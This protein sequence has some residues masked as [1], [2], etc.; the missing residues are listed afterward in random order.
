MNPQSGL[1][2]NLAQKC[3]DHFGDQCDQLTLIFP[4]K[5]SGMYFAQY[6]SKLY[7]KPIW[8]PKIYSLEEFVMG[9]QDKVLADDFQL[10][11]LLYQAYSELNKSP[12]TFDAFMPW[13]EMILSDF[14]DI[15]NYLV[16]PEHIFH[17]VKSQKE[18]DESFRF[19][20]EKDQKI[21][22]QFWKGFIPEPD[23]K[24]NEFIQTW[25]ILSD[26]YI[27]FNELLEA[28]NLTY[29]GR[30]M[31]VFAESEKAIEGKVWFA[32]FNALTRAEEAIIRV[33]MQGDGSDIFW[34]IDD[35]YFSDENQESG[36]FFREYAEDSVFAPSITRDIS[37]MLNQPS[38]EL[39]VFGAPLIHGQVLAAAQLL[40]DLGEDEKPE[41]TLIVLSDESMLDALIQFL[42][43]RFSNYNITMGLSLGQSRVYMLCL[44]L[45]RLVEKMAH[46]S[47][48]SFYHLEVKK[49][50]DFG[51]LLGKG[52]EDFERTLKEGQKTNKLNYEIKE[53]TSL[54]PGLHGLLTLKKEVPHFLDGLLELLVQVYEQDLSSFEKACCTVLHQRV[55]HLKT[56]IEVHAVK[57]DK[58]CFSKL[59]M[60]F[61]NQVKIPTE[62]A[63]DQGL[64]VMG[65][66]ETRN[67][68]FK[69]VYILGMNEGNWPSSSAQNSFIPYNIRR[70]F[71]LPVLDH[72]DAMQSYLFYRLIQNAQNVTVL[73]N[74]VTEYN[75]N[76]ELSRYVQQ[77]KHESQLTITDV[78]VVNKAQMESPEPIVIQKEGVVLEKLSRYLHGRSE[79]QKALS[80]S[81]INSYLDCRLRF[82]FRYVDDLY[83]PDELKEDMD[84]GTMG[85]ILHNSMEYLYKTQKNWASES[86]L[87]VH[88]RIDEA[89][90]HA[91]AKEKIASNKENLSGR[92][93]IA[94]DV[95]KQYIEAILKYDA[96]NS[97]FEII[98]LEKELFMTISIETP[99]SVE[100]VNLK[101]IID[102]IDRT[103]RSVRIMDYKSGRDERN[104]RSVEDLVDRDSKTRNKAAFQLF[105]YSLLYKQNYSTDS[106]P[107]LPG[108]FNSKDLFDAKF[109]AHLYQAIE[110]K[111]QKVEDYEEY[112]ED[113]RV[114]L[115]NLL[116]EIFNPMVDFTQTE[117]GKKCTYCPYNQICMRV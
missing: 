41:E 46:A 49:L 54:F 30:L 79:S 53:I 5:R 75:H 33:T 86:V 112:E 22:H 116:T 108:L 107:I 25:A 100:Q 76:G 109:D 17:V 15:D 28:K 10:L 56:S 89:L 44:E 102:R 45:V 99:S 72:Q 93:L 1:L 95:V 105:Y 13:G 68:I 90:I 6:L 98:D 58:T 103:E 97:P 24:Q 114:G 110:R 94:Y 36:L 104:F 21:I 91:F 80:P 82:Y 92:H 55:K 2:E 52:S 63:I 66:L 31:R 78:S 67:L 40:E 9:L 61:G 117:D 74:N 8:S 7:N 34:E 23:K 57:L 12:E 83:E 47:F 37:S 26:L 27:Q 85:N 42:P 60:R 51:D 77:L 88:K 20:S 115:G 84:P 62:G 69:N 16:D 3:K 19:L 50:F 70:A 43:E 101:G 87:Q 4:N 73:Y 65:I 96:E 32:G 106:K 113:F 64:Q 59:F 11:V 38:T 48:K 71:E 14:N 111:K 35:Y 39:K 29:K 18:L 81:A